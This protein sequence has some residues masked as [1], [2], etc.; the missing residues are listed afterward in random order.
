MREAKKHPSR[1]AQ[2]VAALLVTEGETLVF[3]PPAMA[4]VRA[5]VEVAAYVKD[6]R[7][8]DALRTLVRLAVGLER[9]G[10]PRASQQLLGAISDSKAA[11][12]ALAKHAE[13]EAAL[14]ASFVGTGVTR[15]AP[16]HDAKVEGIPLRTILPVNVGRRLEPAARRGRRAPRPK[17]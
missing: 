9:G 16:Q 14:V 6:H 13:A 15:R 4:K 2:R 11:L 8:V 12:R 5:I 3:P 7:G 17:N 10:Y 1:I